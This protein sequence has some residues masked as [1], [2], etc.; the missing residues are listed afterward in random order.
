MAGQLGREVVIV[1]AVAHRR[2]GAGTP[3]RATTRTSI[4]ADLLGHTYTEVLERAGIDPAEVEYVIA[5]CVQ[6][7]GEQS[8]EHRPQRVAAGGLAD[9]GVGEHD[10]PAVRLRASRPSASA[11]R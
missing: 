7:F 11:R 6:Q 8:H 3:R 1:E 10:R 2:S 5:G 4:P 9:R